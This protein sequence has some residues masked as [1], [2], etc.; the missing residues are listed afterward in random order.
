M[1]WERNELSDEIKSILTIFKGFSLK[2]IKQFLLEGESPALSAANQI[3][4]LNI[5]IQQ[6]TIASLQTQT[7]Q[8]QQN[9]TRSC[10]TINFTFDS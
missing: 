1:P 6:Q 4:S 8:Y 3:L 5:L 7:F 9:F 10:L 2:Q